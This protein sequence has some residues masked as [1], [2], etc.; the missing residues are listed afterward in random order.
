MAYAQ[1][2]ASGISNSVIIAFGFLQFRI[3]E[4]IQLYVPYH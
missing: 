4:A 1:S 2:T 3:S